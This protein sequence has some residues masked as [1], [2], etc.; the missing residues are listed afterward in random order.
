MAQTSEEK[1]RSS[2]ILTVLLLS[3]FLAAELFC[4]FQYQTYYA[5]QIVGLPGGTP[6]AIYIDSEENAIQAA[7]QY[8]AYSIEQK[9]GTEAEIVTGKGEENRGI[10]I[11][12]GPDLPAYSEKKTS[13]LFT[14]SVTAANVDEDNV[15]NIR[16]EENGLS[17][18]VPRPEDCFGVVWAIA[19]RWL[20]DD[21]G[22]KGDSG[23]IINQAIIDRQLSGLQTEVTGKI[24]I[25]TQNL[26][27]R[28]DG[29]GLTITERSARL[30]Q[31]INEYEPDLIGT[32]ECTWE[33]L[34]I[35]Q[36]TLSD[37]YELFGCSREG[38]NTYKGEWNTILFRK[39]RFTLRQGNTFWLSNTPS[40][41]A[42]KL[43]YDGS[44][45]ICTWVLLQDSDTGKEFLFGN[46]HLHHHNS[47][48]YRALRARQA[49]VILWKL[50]GYGNTVPR[51]PE[52]LTGDFNGEPDEPFYSVMTEVYDDSRTTA[53]VNSSR[54]SYSFHDYGQE[55]NLLD[56]CFH[57]PGNTTILDYHILDDQYNGYVSDHYGILIT[58]I[59]N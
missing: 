48:Y 41:S 1:K 31:L 55:E 58:A 18:L 15:Y 8:L 57:S 40:E 46:T 25:L 22:L 44:P 35:L 37:R 21:C 42:S 53:I 9:A 56:Y 27:N 34:Q 12:C 11:L 32:Q 30:F 47:D 39:D 23:L 29:E 6:V 26:R 2:A 52:F 17:I 45:R 49:E 13:L 4:I 3:A 19:D 7:A 14:S 28:D 51:Y 54:I 59:L 50:N 20:Q 36:D 33:W 38:P 5:K 43:N 10:H 24:R 16:L